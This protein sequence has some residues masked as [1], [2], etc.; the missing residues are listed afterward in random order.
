MEKTLTINKMQLSYKLAGNGKSPVILLHGWGCDKHIWGKVFDT[1]SENFT[2]YA[3]D[4]PGFGSSSEPPN[5]WGAYEY[6]NLTKQFLQQLN[7]KNAILIGHSF[8]GRVSIILGSDQELFLKKI[9]LVG[10]AGVKPSRGLNYYTK[11]YSYKAL[12]QL[13][14]LVPNKKWQANILTQWR[15]KVGSNDYQKASPIMRQTLVRVVNE[16][17]QDKM[18][19]IRVPCLLIWGKNDTATPVSD[20]KIME[21]KIP[22]AGLVVLDNCGHYCFLEQQYQFN[23]IVDSFL[24]E[25]K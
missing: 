17:L 1:L 11:V 21:Q 22:D 3:L 24:K 7:I 13:L 18:P 25:D 6:A 4:F 2:T 19:H 15:G 14:K 8:G 20:A 16:D 12:K 9:I 5:A 23:L 10:S